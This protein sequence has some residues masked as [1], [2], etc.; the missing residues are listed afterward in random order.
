M[1]NKFNLNDSKI[2]DI[3]IHP[4]HRLTNDL[5]DISEELKSFIDSTL[6]RQAIGSLMYLV[7]STRPDIAYAV[8]VLSRFMQQPRELHWCHVKRLLKYVKATKNYN[9]VYT[10]SEKTALLG[11]SD[12]DYAND[13]D[14]RR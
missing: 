11:Y 3:P 6:Y 13:I 1:I 14:D 7:T 4:N 5:N 8:S 12:A 2:V 10:K 9:L